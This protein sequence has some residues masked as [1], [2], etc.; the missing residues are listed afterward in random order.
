MKS[1]QSKCKSITKVGI[2]AVTTKGNEI[3]TGIG[4][5]KGSKRWKPNYRMR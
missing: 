2:N 1:D 5:R 4:Y 3:G